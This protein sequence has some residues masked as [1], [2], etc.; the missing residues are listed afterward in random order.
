[1]RVL[2]GLLLLSVASVRADEATT[3]FIAALDDADRGM[4]YAAVQALGKARSGLP[5]IVAL[6]ADPE[7][8]VRQAAG[9]CELVRAELQ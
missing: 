5:E 3:Q 4:R 2:A 1:M 8:C 9:A 7:W 6:L